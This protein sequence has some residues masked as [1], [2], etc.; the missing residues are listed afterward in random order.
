ANC[1]VKADLRVEAISS[2]AGKTA[3]ILDGSAPIFE[4][5]KHDAGL[6]VVQ[7]T[8]QTSVSFQTNDDSNGKTTFRGGQAPGLA[9]EPSFRLICPG[10]IERTVAVTAEADHRY[11]LDLGWKTVG[12]GPFIHSSARSRIRNRIALAAAGPS[13]KNNRLK[14]FP[15]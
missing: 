10:L 9:T 11:F 7:P 13:S 14:H 3:K 6:I 12:T 15:W 2:P 8:G 1:D 5:V 4:A